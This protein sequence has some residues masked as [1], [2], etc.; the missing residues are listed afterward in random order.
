VN[1]KGQAYS[2]SVT[3]RIIEMEDDLSSSIFASGGWTDSINFVNS[4]ISEKFSIKTMSFWKNL[5][6]GK[7]SGDQK[8]VSIRFGLLVVCLDRVGVTD[9]SRIHH[10]D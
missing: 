9:P 1:P 8:P 4:M 6:E 3:A 10:R 2:R 7:P 5:D